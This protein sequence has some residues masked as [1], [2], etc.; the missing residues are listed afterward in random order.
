MVCGRLVSPAKTFTVIV[1][2]AWR[3]VRVTVFGPALNVG[4]AMVIEILA[5]AV[6]AVVEPLTLNVA[7]L[8]RRSVPAAWPG[9]G[10]RRRTFLPRGGHAYRW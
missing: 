10:C 8:A 9:V 4:S 3:N 2:G 7:E 6:N 1:S 5:R